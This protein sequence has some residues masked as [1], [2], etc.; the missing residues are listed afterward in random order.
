MRGQYADGIASCEEALRREPS[1]LLTIYNLALAY[2]TL[3][4][5]T[6]ALEWVNRGLRIDP[7]DPDLQRLEFRLRVLRAVQP[8]RR[9]LG[10]LRFWKR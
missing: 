2:Q 10:W 9:A 5:Y 7:R 8:V 3:R 1:S 4:R 6:P